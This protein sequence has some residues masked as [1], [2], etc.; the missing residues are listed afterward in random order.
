M[1]QI[2]DVSSADLSRG[3]TGTGGEKE[4]ERVPR[5]RC[6]AV[7]RPD[8]SVLWRVWAPQGDPRRPRPVGRP[9]PAHR[10]DEGRARR[11]LQPRRAGRRRRPALRLPPRRRRGPPRPLLAVAARRRPRP[12][13][14]RPARSGSPGPTPAGRACRGKTWSSTSC[15]SA[16]S[17]PRAR[18]RRSSP[19]C[20]A[21]ANW[22]SPPSSS[23]RWASSPA[24]ATGAT[25]ACCPT[26]PRTAT[27]GRTAC[28]K[29]VDAC[30]AR[31]PGGRSSTWST[32][33]SAP[34]GTTCTSSAPTSPTSY[35]TPWGTAV[36]YDDRGCDA[37][38][39]F[40]LD[41]ARMWLEEFHLDGL[42]LDAVH[43]I[44]DLG[45]RHILRAIKEVAEAVARAGRA[46][47]PRRRRERPERPAA[48]AAAGARRLRPGRAVERRLPPRRPRLPHRR[49]P[50]LLRGLRPG[51]SNWPG[52]WRRRSCTPGTTART[53]AAST[54]R[55]PTGLAGDR[56]VV[57][58]QN[59]DQVGNRAR[60]D[61]LA[62]AARLARPS[63][64]WRPA[65]CC[66][67]R[68]CRCCSWARSTAR[69]NPFPFFC[70]FRG[71][72]LVQAVREGRKRRVRRLRLA[73]ARCPTRSA[74]AHLR[75]RRG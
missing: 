50:R 45:A 42:R 35:K 57:C 43:A 19:G 10:R 71:A 36:N 29:L 60:G 58:I 30:H 17:R 2:L 59:H 48:A 37:V 72:E 1:S 39:D 55:R 34:R 47:R 16:P 14:R 65:C 11:V 54:A 6:G 75:S 22:A 68:T 64:G 74:E 49:A 61:R 23:C 26:P 63:C 56:F 62:H 13:R 51:A 69:T 66:S 27:A 24:R 21:C 73:R 9:R 38:R 67:R 41:N 44:Y 31:R 53:A 46:G 28:Q 15:T 4:A 7:G 20:R 18:S 12:V 70:S 8:G 33:T 3:L 25:T 40:V 52:R 5:R 32:T